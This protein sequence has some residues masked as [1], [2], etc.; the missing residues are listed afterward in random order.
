MAEPDLGI[1]FCGLSSSALASAATNVCRWN[2]APISIAH[3]MVLPRANITAEQVSQLF[4]QC[5]AAWS[6]VCRID[7]RFQDD[8]NANILANVD[9]MDGPGGVLGES[10]LPCGNVNPRTQLTQRYDTGEN[11][12]LSFLYRVILHEVGHALGLPHAPQGSA[13]MSPYLTDFATPQGWDIQQMQQRY[14]GAPITPQV[15]DPPAK[16]PE[17]DEPGEPEVIDL[18]GEGGKLLP[19][20]VNVVVPIPRAGNY[21]IRLR[22]PSPKKVRISMTNR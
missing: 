19:F 14:P 22:N 18:F 8:P 4:R 5:V 1:P 2:H 10:Y 11:W 17:P 13:V 15:P 6:S 16:P 3:R 21:L 20:P 7:L 9:A 12:T